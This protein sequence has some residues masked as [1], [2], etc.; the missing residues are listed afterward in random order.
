MEFLDNFMNK[1]V[2]R[3]PAEEKYRGNCGDTP[4]ITFEELSELKVNEV[5]KLHHFNSD[6]LEW[7]IAK[8]TS[9]RIVFR[10]IMEKGATLI[11]H[12]HDCK[13]II[14]VLRGA[15]LNKIDKRIFQKA[16]AMEIPP[17][18]LHNLVALEDSVAYIEFKNPKSNETVV[19]G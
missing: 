15:I 16:R 19:N 5:V 9:D 17:Y 12:Q 18:R 3:T 10:V 2:S 11:N 1:L 8:K 14:L 7:R 6:K 13:E 4:T